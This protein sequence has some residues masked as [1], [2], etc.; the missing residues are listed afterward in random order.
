MKGL[1]P[2]G[3]RVE[4]SSKAR[5]RALWGSKSSPSLA[6]CQGPVPG[7]GKSMTREKDPAP[8]RAGAGHLASPCSPRPGPKHWGFQGGTWGTEA[9]ETSLVRTAEPEAGTLGPGR[10]STSSQAQTRRQRPGGWEEWQNRPGQRKDFLLATLGVR[11][12]FLGDQRTIFSR[13][14]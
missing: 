10:G 2:S 13:A 3:L 11:G 4:R 6:I 7:T 1:M 12:A 14:L 5:T 8:E 9:T